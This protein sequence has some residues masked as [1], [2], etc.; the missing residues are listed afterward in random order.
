MRKLV[1]AVLAAGGLALVVS[2]GPALAISE[3]DPLFAK[4]ITTVARSDAVAY[5]VDPIFPTDP[6]YPTDPLHGGAVATTAL[7]VVGPDDPG[8]DPFTDTC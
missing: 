5:P 6:I 3:P 4:A 8:C 1:V 7:L 2:A